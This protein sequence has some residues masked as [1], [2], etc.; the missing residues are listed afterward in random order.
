MIL[1]TVIWSSPPPRGHFIHRCEGSV[2]L[3]G[4]NEFLAGLLI[5]PGDDA[6]SGS[7]RNTYIRR[8]NM[9]LRDE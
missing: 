6:F 5:D 4:I 7:P 2:R 8:F 9:I 1:R 3:A